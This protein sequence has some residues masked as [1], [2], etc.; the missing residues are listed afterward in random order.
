MMATNGL[1]GLLTRRTLVPIFM[2]SQMSWSHAERRQM[3]INQFLP[4]ST[5]T[6]LFWESGYIEFD[7]VLLRFQIP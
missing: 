2:A 5:A 3:V 1:N 6:Q 4:P 7:C